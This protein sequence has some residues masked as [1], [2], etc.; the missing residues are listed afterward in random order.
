MRPTQVNKYR[1][2]AHDGKTIITFSFPMTSGDLESL[3]E[4]AP[5]V[6][7]IALAIL[8]PFEAPRDG[9]SGP[10][11]QYP[12]QWAL[13]HLKSLYRRA[14]REVYLTHL[15]ALHAYLLAGGDVRNPIGLFTYRLNQE[16]LSDGAIR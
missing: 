10:A 3:L 1:T 4:R 6:P 9:S 15:R 8:T 2:L 11:R 14:G 7:Y 13:N 16:P 12:T 5:N